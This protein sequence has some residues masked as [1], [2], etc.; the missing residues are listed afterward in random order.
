MHEANA[1]VHRSRALIHEARSRHD[2]AAAELNSEE[3]DAALERARAAEELLQ[4][5]EHHA[6]AEQE[7]GQEEEAR[8]DERRRAEEAERRAYE[9]RV[10][11]RLER[12]RAQRRRQRR[13]GPGRSLSGSPAISSAARPAAEVLDHEI[14]ALVRGL[15][16]HGPATSAE[17]RTLVGARF[18]GPGVFNQ[19][20]SEA[21]GSGEIRRVARR[22]YAAADEV[23]EDEAGS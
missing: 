15:T 21:V 6:D 13:L 18:W 1:A 10:R 16:E 5:A 7:R 9:R 4:A 20:L 19:A 8:Q 14:G 3:A 23:D 11:L 22:T 2:D 12:A 17:L